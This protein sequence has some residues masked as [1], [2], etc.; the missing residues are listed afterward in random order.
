MKIGDAVPVLGIFIERAPSRIIE[1]DM[2]IQSFLSERRC[3]MQ[4]IDIERLGEIQVREQ[5]RQNR[6]AGRIVLLSFQQSVD[7]VV[8]K[9]E[10]FCRA[11]VIG[12]DFIQRE[13]SRVREAVADDLPQI[14]QQS[15]PLAAEYSLEQRHVQPLA[16]SLPR[17]GLCC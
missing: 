17:D 13:A 9:S 14:G 3:W 11:S 5:E 7:E 12:H 1:T 16:D 2:R 6:K 10:V 8:V 4:M 15:V